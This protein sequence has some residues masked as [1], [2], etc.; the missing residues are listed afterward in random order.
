[1]LGLL[2]AAELAAGEEAGGV[3]DAAV[4]ADVVELLLQ[5]AT[6]RARPRPSAGARIVRRAKSLN[7][8]TRLLNLGLKCSH[9][10]QN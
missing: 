7:C 9:S 2:G 8:M 1:V 5:A 3:L 10:E 4:D 6:V